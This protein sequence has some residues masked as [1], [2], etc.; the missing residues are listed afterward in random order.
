[1]RTAQ[2]MYD[3]CIT[4]GYGSGF[5]RNTALNHFT[6]IEEA[7]QPTENVL[8]TF[9]GLHNFRGMTSHNNNF[10]YAI[11]NKRVIY[12]QKGFLFGGT[13]KSVNLNN[14][15][16]ITI[17]VG[18]IFGIITFDYFKETFNVAVDKYTASNIYTKIQE[19]LYQSKK[20]T[21]NL[22]L[23]AADE[24]LKYKQLLDMGVITQ[25]EFELKKKELLGK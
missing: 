10:A 7:L 5:S 11:T 15:N 21:N 1:M 18:A 23:S 12:A 6:L 8:M 14:L 16:D 3:Y 13:I 19:I 22:Q 17:S 24:L 2:E 20:S 25:S 9:I 4:N